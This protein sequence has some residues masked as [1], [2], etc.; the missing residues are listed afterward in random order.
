MLAV[1]TRPVIALQ[2]GFFYDRHHFQKS[3]HQIFTRQNSKL[4]T[5]MAHVSIL[6]APRR[7]IYYVKITH[8]MNERKALTEVKAV[9]AIKRTGVQ[10]LL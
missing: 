5:C 9:F 1:Q 8:N 6:F 4:L 2:A 7:M 10:L 3:A